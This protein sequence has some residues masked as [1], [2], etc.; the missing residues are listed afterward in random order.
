M[1]EQPAKNDI[2]TALSVLMHEARRQTLDEKNRITSEAIKHG[3][4][5]SNR[6][7]VAV[8]DAA[9]KV[10][11][12]SM[13]QAKQILIDFVQ[14]MER[15]ATEITAWAR[16]HLENLS[17]TVLGVVP[18]NGFP[19]DHQRIIN[20][21]RAVFQ[22]RVDITLRGVEI[23]YVRGAGFTMSATA[24]ETEEWIS[25]ARAVTLLGL[26]DY[27]SR[28]TI[29]KRAH[30]GLIKAR[31]ERFIRGGQAADNVDI[32]AAFWWAEGHEA[33]EQ[34]WASGD[35]GTWIEQRIRLQ[36][37]GVIFLRSD[38]ER[39]KP[40]PA[41]EK[42]QNK[43]KA[44][45]TRIFIGHGRSLVWHELRTFLKERLKLEVDEFNSVATA[46]IPTTERLSEMLDSAAFAF[47]IM[48]AEDE[49]PDG[50]FNARLNVIHEAGLFQGRLGFKKAI[51]LLEDGCDEF[52]NI[53]G[54]GQIRFSRGDISARFEQIR[55]VL[56]REKI[57]T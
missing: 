17:N 9:D 50:K 40:A 5:Q 45:A 3:A 57:I 47:L 26:G 48:T 10:H 42:E 52:S 43:M 56:E 19:D 20:Q 53:H 12:A 22:Q 18:P 54:L 15:P 35:F 51:V 38:I 36:A 31:A 27:S 6:V 13:T 28:M 24:S 11:N 39:L 1:F 25:A 16:P 23:G 33:L 21:Y 2:D 41:L 46:G 37:F 14:R 8:V 29:C 30:A 44:T 32:P 55:L 49:T 4:L 34:N 7:I